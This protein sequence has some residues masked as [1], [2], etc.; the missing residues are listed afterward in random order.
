MRLSIY[1]VIGIIISVTTL[2]VTILSIVT[3]S[4]NQDMQHI[5]ERIDAIYEMILLEQGKDCKIYD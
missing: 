1:T 5:N 2:N 3:S 4:I